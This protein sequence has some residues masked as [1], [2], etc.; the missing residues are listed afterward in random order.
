MTWGIGTRQSMNARQRDV[1]DLDLFKALYLVEA[2]SPLDMPNHV[3]QVEPRKRPL[4]R[5]KN[6]NLHLVDTRDLNHLALLP[7]PPVLLGEL[8]SGNPS[9][10]VLLFSPD[11]SQTLFQTVLWADRNFFDSQL[12]KRPDSLAR[13]SVALASALYGGVQEYLFEGPPTDSISLLDKAQFEARVL[14]AGIRFVQRLKASRFWPLLNEEERLGFENA[15]QR[16]KDNLH[17][18]HCAVQILRG[19]NFRFN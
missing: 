17:A 5:G 15:D 19:A 13:V 14:D 2:L 3:F 10:T 8:Q 18:V 16:F 12:N 7:A 4:V 6:I 1:A 9:E 11:Y